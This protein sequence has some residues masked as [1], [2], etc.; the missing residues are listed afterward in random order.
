MDCCRGILPLPK[1][2]YSPRSEGDILSGAQDWTCSLAY[3]YSTACV[4]TM[5]VASIM[6][7]QLPGV[8]YVSFQEKVDLQQV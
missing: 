7:S 4:T 1:I 5:Y 3:V 6:Y 8:D 2:G